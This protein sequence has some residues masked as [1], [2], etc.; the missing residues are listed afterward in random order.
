MNHSEKINELAIALSTFQG[1]VEPIKKDAKNPF[2]KNKYA[3]LEALIEGT[4]NILKKYN[5][6][7]SQLIEE[8]SLT[9]MLMHGSGQYIYSTM[10]LKE[11][12]GKG[13]SASQIQGVSIT[14]ARRYAYSAILGLATEEDTDGSL[15]SANPSPVRQ[16]SPQPKKTLDE[17]IAEGVV[18]NLTHDFPDVPKSSN[19]HFCEI[20]NKPLKDRGKGI[21][22]HRAKLNSE[23]Q[24]DDNGSWHHCQGNGWKLSPNQ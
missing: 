1:E 22:D 10:S 11:G 9:T 3:S 4:K 24:S 15:S 16:P 18:E 6:S 2:L 5:L 13:L 14:Y 7:V 21:W 8:G 12:D 20:H 17:Q 19:T 23:G